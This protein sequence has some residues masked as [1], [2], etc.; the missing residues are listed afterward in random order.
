MES[1]EGARTWVMINTIAWVFCVMI[2]LSHSMPGWEVQEKASCGLGD[3]EGSP[4]YPLREVPQNLC[5]E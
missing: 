4:A 1:P 3:G 2:N 5:D